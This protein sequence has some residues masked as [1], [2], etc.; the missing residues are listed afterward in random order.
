[1]AGYAVRNEILNGTSVTSVASATTAITPIIRVTDRDSKNILVSVTLSA[2]SETTGLTVV[3]QDSPDGS[4]FSTVKSG[5]ITS[6]AN[7]ETLTFPTKAGATHGDYFVVYDAAGLGW[8]I[9]LD[10]TG[11]GAVPSGAIYTA[12]PAA[13][14]A[15]ANI[16]TDTTAAE[17]AARVELA[18][19]ALTGATAA[20]V[21]D[22]SAA[23]GTMTFT[24]VAAGV[25]TTNAVLKNED[26]SGAG[27]ITAAQ[28]TSGSFTAT[29]ELE[30]NIYN[31]SDTAMWPLARVAIVGGAGDVATASSCLVT[32]RL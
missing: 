15:Q 9:A 25:N 30:N 26:D 22:D 29:V 23:D 31:G 16:S 4:T 32:R 21:T 17:V 28:T 24:A 5:N 10:K 3:L 13:R 27:S 18:F 11:G 2:V 7:V 20:L 1:M 12:I 8:A 6:V 14:K 19:D